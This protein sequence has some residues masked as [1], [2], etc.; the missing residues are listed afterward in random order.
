MVM[1]SNSGEGE[2]MDFNEPQSRAHFIREAID[3]SVRQAHQEIQITFDA[4]IPDDEDFEDPLDNDNPFEQTEWGADTGGGTCFID[5]DL[6]V[7]EEYL[8]PDEDLLDDEDDEDYESESLDSTET[9][10]MLLTLLSPV[11][12]K[13]RLDEDKEERTKELT[14]LTKLVEDVIQPVAQEESTLEEHIIKEFDRFSETDIQLLLE[15]FGYHGEY[16]LYGDPARIEVP[17]IIPIAALILALAEIVKNILNL[18][19][20]I[21][22][23]EKNITY[24]DIHDA[25]NHAEDFYFDV[26]NEFCNLTSAEE[27]CN[28][29]PLF[30]TCPML[31]N[32]LK[33]TQQ[34]WHVFINCVSSKK[35][36]I[37]DALTNTYY[38]ENMQAL[39][40]AGSTRPMP[41]FLMTDANTNAG[42][43][44]NMDTL[45][46]TIK[47]HELHGSLSSDDDFDDDFDGD[48]DDEAARQNDRLQ[49]EILTP[50][51]IEALIA[52]QADL[53]CEYITDLVQLTSNNALYRCK[54]L[55]E[56]LAIRTKEVTDTTA[57]FN[58]LAMSVGESLLYN[59]AIKPPLH[60]ILPIH[61]ILIIMP[62]IIADIQSTLEYFKNPILND[63]VDADSSLATMY[64]SQDALDE[65]IDIIEARETWQY[66]LHAT[67]TVLAQNRNHAFAAQLQADIELIQ[68]AL[69]DFDAELQTKVEYFTLLGSTH[70][71]VN[72]RALWQAATNLPCPNFLKIV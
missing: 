42:D 15:Y 34:Y 49:M 60:T 39:W 48:D 59:T 53:R 40:Q 18:I 21:K 66:Q 58:Q 44:V 55:E 28:N 37:F 64:T 11:Q 41:N 14:R 63:E 61:I 20:L 23:L 50:D 54:K 30:G 16:I 7:D 1:Q 36:N 19:K 46:E 56:I 33:A 52:E 31:Q 17:K 25:K 32:Q 45:L 35:H 47:N 51:E 57:H 22:N 65:Q 13:N 68:T 62:I 5:D 12:I 9:D 71:L 43:T 72:K 27:Y 38:F 3:K 67:Q 4:G 26:M 10:Q 2:E 8:D 70:Y 6:E 69:Q 29:H 24:L